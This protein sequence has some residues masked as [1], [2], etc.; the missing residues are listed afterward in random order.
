VGRW[1]AGLEAPEEDERGEY[2]DLVVLVQWSAHGMKK[3]V[4]PGIV[5]REIIPGKCSAMGKKG[6]RTR[7]AG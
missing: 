1:E 3:G 2:D 5:W 4:S 7:A 6:Q